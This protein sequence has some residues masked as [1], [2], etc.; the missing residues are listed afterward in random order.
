M[1]C[2]QE[3]KLQ[4]AKVPEVKVKLEEQLPGWTS[5]FDC[6]TVRKG[7]AGVA[8]LFRPG[9]VWMA[10]GC[11]GTCHLTRALCTYVYPNI[12]IPHIHIPHNHIPH[13]P[14]SHTHPHIPSS[15]TIL[16]HSVNPLSVSRPQG[17]LA[18]DNEGRVL[19]AEFETMY[20]VTVY[21]PNSGKPKPGDKDSGLERLAY[22]VD[23][24]GWDCKLAQTLKVWWCRWWCVVC[25]VVCGVCGVPDGVWLHACI[26]M[27]GQ[28]SLS[29]SCNGA[30]HTHVLT[31]TPFNATHHTT[32]QTL[33]KHKPVILGGDLNVAYQE[34]DI[35]SPKTNQKSAGYV[36]CGC[37][38][39]WMYV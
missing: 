30:H 37:M 2:I 21:V 5:V 27:S 8:M 25:L 18:D 39:M 36:Y 11:M 20:V 24:G 9:Y 4:E 38:W 10:C 34:I 1:L 13:P 3:H 33:E 35:H 32:Q 19:V 14:S 29:H 16:T 17:P 22:R 31:H 15:H 26:R 6:S 23:P 28:V 12:P 7:Y